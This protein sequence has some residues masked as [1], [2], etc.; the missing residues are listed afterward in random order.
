MINGIGGNRMTETI[1]SY[2]RQDARTVGFTLGV[3]HSFAIAPDGSRIAF[4]RARSGTDRNTC[5]WVRDTETGIERLVA[6]PGQ[7]LGSA[8]ESLSP[9]ERAR[10]ERVR[11]AAGGVVSFATDDAVS[12]AAF[13]LSGQI[14]VV[15]LADPDQD[16]PARGLT[17]PRPVIDPRPDPT[18]SHIAYVVEG[19]LRVTSADGSG[20][21]ALAGPEGPNVSYGLAEFVAAEEMG[22]T[23]GFWWSPDGRR[24]LVARVDTTPVT[25]WHIADPANPDVPPVEVAYPAAG[26]ANAAVSV[27]IAGLDGTVTPVAWDPSD[28]P[29]LTAV[30]WSAGGPPLLQVCSRDQRT[31]RVLAV[32]DDGSVN[33][34]CEDTDPAWVDVV[35]GTPAWTTDGDL[36][37]V[38]ARDGAYRLMIGDDAVTPQGL[39][40]SDVLDVGDDVLLRAT[41]D[42]PAQLHVYAAGRGGVSA[43]TTE[44]GWHAAARSGEVTVTTSQSLA[45]PGRRVRMLR[46]GDLA[47]EITSL[48]QTPVIEPEVTFFTAGPD[49]LRCALLLPRRHRPGS[50][51]LP[52]LCDPYGGPAGQRVVSARGAYLTPQWF[53]DQGFAVLIADG[54]GT[55]GRGPAWDRLIKF[56]EATPNVE[57]QVTAL[58]A[59]AAACPDLDLTRVGIRGWSHGGYLAALA[60]LRRPDVFH[61]AVAGAPVTDKRLYDTFYTERYLG[62][63]DER[64]EAYDHNSLI[65]DAPKLQRP[66]MLIHGLIDDNV[67]VAH[68]LRLSAALLAAGR[69][70]TVLPLSGVTHMARQEEVAE[71]LLLLQVDFLKNALGG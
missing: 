67:V 47:S 32:A 58:E 4:L 22:R 64:P 54:R 12:M 43:V 8:V 28:A 20:D 48:A 33:L 1:V 63:P 36:V 24:L 65:A 62:L 51:K 10:R 31:M 49:E 37:R 6:D 45:W 57:D 61:A 40:V 50:A 9:V 23:R 70:H 27:I 11:Q 5:L 38:A 35:A 7:L 39:N 34:V 56:D 69:P 18:G 53:A 16:S 30:H 71:N 66:L 2:P 13:T 55:P 60:V 68:T 17:T 46:D 41:S 59:A 42:D 15:R 52:V 3:P 21:R 14:F 19:T 26:T 29:Y 44:P 25:R